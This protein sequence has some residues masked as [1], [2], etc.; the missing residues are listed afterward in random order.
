MIGVGG[1]TYRTRGMSVY[2]VYSCGLVGENSW[3]GIV[4]VKVVWISVVVD[5]V[6]GIILWVSVIGVMGN[7]TGV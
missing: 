3:S 7:D 1:S 4:W 2:K 6:L 5:V